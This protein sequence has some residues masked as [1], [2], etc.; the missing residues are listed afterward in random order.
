MYLLG[1]IL[2]EGT[3]IVTK[4]G[5]THYGVVAEHNAAVFQQRTVGN[6]LH[7]GHQVTTA[8]IARSKRTGPS[9]CILQHSTLVG[10]TL[11]LGIAQSGADTRVGNATHAVHLRIII[12]SQLTS[13]FLT[14]LLYVDA[15]IVA[16]R[17]TVVN[18]QE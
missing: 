12:L 2:K 8:L 14:H 16:G 4:L 18:P 15:F 9:G 6:K 11:T 10:D 13:V 7:P 17:E 1:T 5:A 3:H